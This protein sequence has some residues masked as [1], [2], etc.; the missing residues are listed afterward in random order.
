MACSTPSGT[1]LRVTIVNQFYTPDIPPTAHFAA[2]LAEHLAARGDQVTVIASRGGYTT[3]SLHVKSPETHKNPRIYRVWTPR[4]GKAKVLARLADYACFYALAAWHA[5]RLPR[6][7]V[8]VCMTTPP[9]IAWVAVFHQWLHPRT[10]LLLWNMDCYPEAIER[11]GVIKP[12]GLLSRLMRWLNRRLFRRL[13]QLVCLDRA[14]ADLLAAYMPNKTPGPAVAVIPSWEKAA[15][16]PTT[17]QAEIPHT[18]DLAS[19]QGRFIILY[20][21]NAGVGHE[22]G[23]VLQA[24]EILKDTEVLFLFVGGGYRTAEIATEKKARK[25]SNVLLFD[26]IQK[27]QTPAVMAIASCALITLSDHALGVM[28]PSKLHANLAMGLPIL[29]VGPPAS[30]VDEAINRFQ[31]GK[32]LRHGDIN[33]LVSAITALMNQTNHATT[34]SKAAR[35]A[36][37]SAYCDRVVLPSFVQLIDNLG[38]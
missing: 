3:Q 6:Q 34:Q 26:Y 33:G 9:F 28:S 11:F 25:L 22:F 37:E 17:L 29:Y 4:L 12:N 38:P 36:F 15:L 16:F 21:G 32:S 10:R 2:S 5:L 35:L 23:T 24:A 8:F 27:D 1:G 13:D 19:L 31:C 14:T 20:L 18:P 30:N 7:D